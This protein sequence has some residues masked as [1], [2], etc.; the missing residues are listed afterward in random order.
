MG[1]EKST[2]YAFD[3]TGWGETVTL[4][5]VELD[6]KARAISCSV[7]AVSTFISVH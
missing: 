6:A 7:A 3:C 5:F 4:Y 2:S 1:N